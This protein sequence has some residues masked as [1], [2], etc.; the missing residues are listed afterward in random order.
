MLFPIPKYQ[1]T[2]KYFKLKNKNFNKSIY[3]YIYIV[4]FIKLNTTYI[5]LIKLYIITYLP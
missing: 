4:Y 1:L 3:I 5:Y 2:R